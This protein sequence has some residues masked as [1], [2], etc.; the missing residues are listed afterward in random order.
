MS[1]VE[2]A[3]ICR[4]PRMSLRRI[5]AE[6][7]GTSSRQERT[8]SSISSTRSNGAIIVSTSPMMR[9]KSCVLG[10]VVIESPPLLIGSVVGVEA[11]SPGDDIAGDGH[12]V[13]AGAEGLC[14]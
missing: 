3:R 1:W 4:P 13:P 2:L 10:S 9:V 12:E 6:S 14:L 7:A 11:Q 5:P 8:S